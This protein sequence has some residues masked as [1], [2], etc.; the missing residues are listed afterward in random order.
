MRDP[1]QVLRRLDARLGFDGD[2]GPLLTRLRSLPRVV[3]LVAGAVLS[4][5]FA[6][7]VLPP[8]MLLSAP[9]HGCNSRRLGFVILRG[10]AW[11][12]LENLRFVGEDAA[13]RARAFS[14]WRAAAST[15]RFAA[16]GAWR[17]R[18]RAHRADFEHWW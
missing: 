5:C 12:K 1:F 15:L 4:T 2:N 14:V 11:L 17:M 6:G 13:A 9:L 18:V 7:L 3:P 8:S 10:Q 16:H